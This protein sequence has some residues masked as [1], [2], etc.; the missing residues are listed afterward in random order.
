ML[1]ANS[2]LAALFAKELAW[3]KVKPGES[4]A[5]VAEPDSIPH[6]VAASFAALTGVGANAFEV[7]LPVVPNEADDPVVERGVGNCSLLEKLPAIVEM[8]GKTDIIIDLTVEG[9]IHSRATEQILAKGAR[10]LYVREPADALA[11]LLPTRDRTRR[12]AR[13][14]DLLSDAKTMLISSKAGTNL[15]VDLTGAAVQGSWGFCD[16]PGRWANW[17]NGFVAAYPT[18]LNTNGDVVVAPGDILFP[19]KRYVERPIRFR[20]K[21]AFVEEIEGE[22]MDAELVRDYMCRWNDRNAYGISH[23]GWGLHERALWHAMSLYGKEE[24]HGVDGRAFEGNFLF[25]TGPNRAAGRVTACHLDIPVRN[26]SITLD[27]RPILAEGK[28]VEPTIIHAA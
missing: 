10:M 28:I 2:S 5:I 7:I 22:G 14:I 11:R 25:S 13:S 1:Q 15:R 27:N 19:F 20:F 12:I 8:L 3:C 17:G 4:A 6:Y 21:D 24:I 23:I 18:S 26:C 16:Q 9:L